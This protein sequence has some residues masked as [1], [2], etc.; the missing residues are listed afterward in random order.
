MSSALNMALASVQLGRGICG[1]RPQSV[2]LVMPLPTVATACR[3]ALK[4]PPGAN[5]GHEHIVTS[6]AAPQYTLMK[7][8]VFRHTLYKILGS[9]TQVDVDP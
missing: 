6:V 4:A 2:H 7:W 5:S 8:V 1:A 9:V 3:A